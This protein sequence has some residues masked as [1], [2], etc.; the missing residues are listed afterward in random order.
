M[1][2]KLLDQILRVVF[3]IW[4]LLLGTIYLSFRPA[5][6][7]SSEQYTNAQLQRWYEGV[8]EEYFANKLPKDTTVQWG[9][10]S[11]SKDVGTTL[12]RPDG[13]YAI[14]IDPVQNPN[15]RSAAL[16]AYHEMCHVAGPV[17]DFST[18]GPRFQACMLHL[19]EVGAF[20]E[21]W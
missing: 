21:L 11:N 16:T 13:T 20:R 3:V 2:R 17:A 9:D 18:H 4:L 10:L 15:K 5:H 7:S 12:R 6:K 14:W 1:T 19:A 8:N